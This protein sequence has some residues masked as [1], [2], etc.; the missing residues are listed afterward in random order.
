MAYPDPAALPAIGGAIA[1]A[2]LPQVTFH[3]GV[4]LA[5]RL[6]V[7]RR[8]A[9][10][11]PAVKPPR[12][13]LPASEVLPAIPLPHLPEEVAAPVGSSDWERA[14]RTGPTC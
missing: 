12:S 4:R 5:R 3:Q 10:R 9:R 14:S 8:P 11:R 2:Y 7:G 1:K 6:L 13:R